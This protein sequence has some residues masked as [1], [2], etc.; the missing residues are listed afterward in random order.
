MYK[1]PTISPHTMKMLSSSLELAETT[2]RG[3]LYTAAIN[4]QDCDDI[5]VADYIDGVFLEY[6]SSAQIF[7]INITDIL[8]MQVIVP[9]QHLIKGKETY[10]PVRVQLMYPIT[11]A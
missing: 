2:A 11:F 8:R 7:C 10:M 9:G 4:S 3:L 1:L 5:V 6:D